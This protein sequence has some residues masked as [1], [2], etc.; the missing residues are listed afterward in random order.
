MSGPALDA[1]ATHPIAAMFCGSWDQT[2]QSLRRS[3]FAGRPPASVW[4]ALIAGP[5][6]KP[7]GKSRA[8]AVPTT[9]SVGT[10]VKAVRRRKVRGV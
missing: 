7:L 4:K 8:C 6:R 9:V 10:N 1:V 5:N 2:H 3:A